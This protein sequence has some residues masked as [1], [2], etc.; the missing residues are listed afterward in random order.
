MVCS[1]SVTDITGASHARLRHRCIR[2]DWFPRRSRTHQRGPSGQRSRPVG[3]SAGA[4]AAAGVEVYRGSLTT[5][6]SCGAP[7]P[8]RT[9]SF[10]LP[11][12]TARRSRATSRARPM[13]IA[14]LS[15]R[16]PTCWPGP[17][18]RWSSH[19]YAR[20][21]T[22]T[23]RDGEGRTGRRA[24]ARRSGE[25]FGDRTFTV[26]LAS[27]GIRSV[28]VRLSPTV[29]GQGDYGFMARIIGIARDKGVSGYIGDGNNEWP[30]VHVMD[31]AHLFRLAL[32]N[33]PA[34]SVC[35]PSPMKAC[36]CVR[37]RRSWVAS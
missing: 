29:H 19:R 33:A 13:R 25:A 3:T 32:E 5:S 1:M 12:I 4:L 26:S 17:V 27:R 23:H 10:I 36:R 2:L 28:V 18:G 8:R 31:A 34:G 15:K 35:M 37:S 6:T 11:S 14:A 9:A 22:G 7:P 30:A 20:G 24:F 16:S 21:R